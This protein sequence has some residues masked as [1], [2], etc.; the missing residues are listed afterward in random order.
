M[1]TATAARLTL[2]TIRLTR[3]ITVDEVGE[4]WLKNPI[5][6]AML[7][8]RTK[9]TT[10]RL[11]PVFD[12]LDYQGSPLHKVEFFDEPWWWKYRDGLDCGW[13]TSFHVAWIL[14][15]GE[16]LLGRT[17]L[18]RGATTALAIAQVAASVGELLGT[19]DTPEDD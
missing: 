1:N 10:S 16:T 19:Y 8:Y 9:R 13:C 3:A 15:A 6:E 18:W 14:L 12:S 5:D 2:A 4:W 11:V 17:R 7:R